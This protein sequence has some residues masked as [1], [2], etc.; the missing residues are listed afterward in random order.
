MEFDETGFALFTS[1]LWESDGAM[2]SSKGAN[3]LIVDPT[4]RPPGMERQANLALIAQAPAMYELLKQIL[5][6]HDDLENKIVPVLSAA[7]IEPP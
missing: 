6:E 1:G 2:V 5:V 3:K 4:G 7:R